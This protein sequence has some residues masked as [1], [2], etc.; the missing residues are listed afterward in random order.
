MNSGY[1][2]SQVVS[3][4][5]R[6]AP[7]RHFWNE[8]ITWKEDLGEGGMVAVVLPEEDQVANTNASEVLGG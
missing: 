2:T 7:G 6:G 3:R 5:S 1:G 4:M 8:C